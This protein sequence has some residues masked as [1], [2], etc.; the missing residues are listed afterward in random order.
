MNL[1]VADESVVTRYLVYFVYSFFAN[2][3]NDFQE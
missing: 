1:F 3:K 2:E